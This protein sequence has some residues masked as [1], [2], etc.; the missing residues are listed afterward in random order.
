MLHVKHKCCTC[1]TN[2]FIGMYVLD[3]ETQ[4][5]IEQCMCSTKLSIGMYLL[6]CETQCDIE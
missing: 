3:Y 2:I 4:C 6:D 1:S 5:G